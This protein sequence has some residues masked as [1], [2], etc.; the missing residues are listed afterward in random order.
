MSTT[1]TAFCV[2]HENN[3][4]ND[5][6]KYPSISSSNPSR[7]RKRKGVKDIATVFLSGLPGARSSCQRLPE[8]FVILRTKGELTYCMFHWL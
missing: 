8:Y 7:K 5:L 6:R 1:L 3:P 4:T 2:L